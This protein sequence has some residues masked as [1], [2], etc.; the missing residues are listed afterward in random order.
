MLYS[1]CK[2]CGRIYK[3]VS[4]NVELCCEC[5][6]KYEAQY[7]ETL[8][9]IEKHIKDM[10]LESLV[11][12]IGYEPK[13][14]FAYLSN[15]FSELARGA[16]YSS[17]EGHRRDYCYI[18]N[19]KLLYRAESACL[20]CLQRILAVVLE[21]KNALHH[22]QSQPQATDHMAKFYL[23]K[24]LPEVSQ[25]VD[26]SERQGNSPKPLWGNSSAR[27]RFRR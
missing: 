13:R 10:F 21:N 1:N 11:E 7:S 2:L 12:Q 23:A 9:R 25:S 8:K 24:R 26:G 5:M 16:K 20:N 22:P 19:A 17:L 6:S 4:Q 3:G 27:P 18:C 14:V 15:R